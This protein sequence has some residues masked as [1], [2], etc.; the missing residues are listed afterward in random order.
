[1][2]PFHFHSELPKKLFLSCRDAMV[3]VVPSD[4]HAAIEILLRNDMMYD[5]EYTPPPASFSLD[6]KLLLFLI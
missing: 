6:S 1:M 4:S 2:S 5:A 3:P